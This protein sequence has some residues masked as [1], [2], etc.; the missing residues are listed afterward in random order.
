[1]GIIYSILAGVFMSLQGVFNTRLNEKI[2]IWEANVIVQGIGFVVTLIVLL[3]AG[4]GDFKKLH[5]VNKIYLLGGVLGALIIFTVIKGISELGPTYSIATILVAQLATAAIIDCL[6]W[7]DTNQVP[8]H[9]SKIIGV[10][11]MVLGI[12]IFKW[13]C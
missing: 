7:F 9:Y 11:I 8:F 2:G 13:K 6:G 5:D 4:N 10:V 1:M 12:V 3:F